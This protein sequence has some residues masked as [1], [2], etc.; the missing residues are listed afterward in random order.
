M[1]ASTPNFQ[2]PT[3]KGNGSKQLATNDSP[4]ELGGGSWTLFAAL[5][6]VASLYA[7]GGAAQETVDMT[8][9]MIGVGAHLWEEES[10]DERVAIHDRRRGLLAPNRHGGHE[11]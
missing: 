10:G 8:A 5:C 9:A 11:D 4:W 7:T 1:T 3:S 2:L 6:L